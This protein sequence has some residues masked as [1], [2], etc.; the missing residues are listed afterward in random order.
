MK[1]EN[2]KEIIDTQKLEQYIKDIREE[3]DL[4]KKRQAALRTKE[5]RYKKMLQDIN[6]LELL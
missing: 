3:R 6:Q 5:C 4:L 2:L 1:A